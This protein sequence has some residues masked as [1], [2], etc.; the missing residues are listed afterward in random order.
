MND[1][2]TPSFSFYFDLKTFAAGVID[3]RGLAENMCHNVW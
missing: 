2:D 1:K 3:I